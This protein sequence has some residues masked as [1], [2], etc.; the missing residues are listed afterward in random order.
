MSA[1]FLIIALLILDFVYVFVMSSKYSLMINAIQSAHIQVNIVSA[2]VSY[3][4]L[5]VALLFVVIPYAN[6]RKEKDN[7]IIKT[8]FMSGFLIGFIIYGVFNTTN[9]ALF[10]NYSLL[11]AMVDILWG[12]TLF[13]IIALLY[14]SPSVLFILKPVK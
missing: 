12:S 2:V 3:C 14:L 9:V 8:A 6:L 11:L 5:L 13:F 7:N 4:V 10:K 1:L